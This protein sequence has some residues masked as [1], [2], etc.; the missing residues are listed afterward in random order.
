[1]R[2]RRQRRPRALP[3]CGS[4]TAAAD[5]CAASAWLRGSLTPSDQ[6]RERRDAPLLVLVLVHGHDRHSLL[7]PSPSSCCS[8]G[9]IQLWLIFIVQGKGSRPC[10]ASSIPPL[11]VGQ[12]G[13][14]S[15]QPLL[16]SVSSSPPLTGRSTKIHR[17]R[18]WMRTSCC[19]C[20]WWGVRP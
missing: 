10:S 2:S 12:R 1:M 15:S 16:P 7:C 11:V 18:R 8:S 3:R 19:G 20:R 14:T 13:S 9:N 17:Y 6:E 4:M 5:A